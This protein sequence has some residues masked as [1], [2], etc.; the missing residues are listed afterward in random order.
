MKTSAIIPI[1]FAL[2][3]TSSAHSATIFGSLTASVISTYQNGSGIVPSGILV[4][5]TVTLS[6]SYDSLA[7]AN[8]NRSGFAGDPNVAEYGTGLNLFISVISGGYT[9]EGVASDG[10]AVTMNGGVGGFNDRFEVEVS[11]SYGGSFSSFP[12]DMGGDS[13]LA[14]ALSDTIAPLNL[15]DSL[16]LPTAISD[17]NLSA[18]HN[19][20]I[21]I[22]SQLDFNG[23]WNIVAEPNLAS[24]VIIPEPS[25]ILLVFGASS[26]LLCRR[27]KL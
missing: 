6:F 11:K 10:Y 17:L 15:S 27:R 1:S 25:S 23:S 4:G 3:L 26:L 18:A 16:A 22:S 12:G 19:N 14:F 24:L 2:A 7:L 20:G 9:W 21:V 5:T 8:G 13:Y